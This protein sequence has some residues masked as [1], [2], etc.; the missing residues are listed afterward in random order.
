MRAE[1]FYLD[2]N[3]YFAAVEQ[4]LHPEY[5]GRPLVVAPMQSRWTCAISA[6]R[7]AKTLG[8]KTGTKIGEALDI[9][10]ELIICSARHDGYVQMHHQIL[11]IIERHLHVEKVL[12]I[13]DIACR[14][15][16][17]EAP[18]AKEIARVIKAAIVEELGPPMTCSVGIGP[19]LWLAKVATELQKPD[20]LIEIG[21]EDLPDIL[22]SLELRDLP[23]IGHSMERRLH[24]A[25]ITSVPELWACE[26]KRLRAI[27]GN[28]GGEVMWRQL[29]GLEV[30]GPKTRHRT[31]GHSHVLPPEARSPS[32]AL[33]I[34]RRLVTKAASRLRR[35]GHVTG[36]LDL[37]VRL[38]DRPPY[39]GQRLMGSKAL[40]RDGI[41]DTPS[42]LAAV[43]AL[44]AEI[45]PPDIAR[46]PE[47]PSLKKVSIVLHRLSAKSEIQ[48]DLFDNLETSK[49]R[50]VETERKQALSK[51]VDVLNARYGKDTVSYGHMPVPTDR[52]SGA[53]IA[54][55]RVPDTADF[56]S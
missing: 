53:K 44:W 55:G 5:R 3:S 26:P 25:G 38:V 9:C 51:A 12:S 35:M 4:T 21:G 2:L 40:G 15:M 23:G 52:Y 45:L 43:T 6:S 54:F 14:L 41:D 46:H 20:G 17:N 48:P 18:R 13:D 56:S 10:P 19:N 24:R 16:E 22:F 39:W 31:V 42:L 29:R 27:W 37:S 49:H 34:A 47:T 8:I 1:W 7:E 30:Q 36:M 50:Q 28:V 11:A 32:C 33:P